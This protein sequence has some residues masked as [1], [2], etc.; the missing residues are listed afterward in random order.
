MLSP[1][2]LKRFPARQN[3][4]LSAMTFI[5]GRGDYNNRGEEVQPGFPEILRS[6]AITSFPQKLSR[7]ALA[8]WIASAQ[9]PLTARVMVNRIWQHHFGR[10]I[11]PGPSE[12]GT[13]GD[14]PSHPELLDWL[15][16]EFI[17]GGWSIKKLHQLILLSETYQ[18]SSVPSSS[19]LARDPDNRLFSRQNR[20]RLEGEVIRDSLLAISGHLNQTVGGPSIFPPIPADMA[21][22]LN[23]WTVSV[24]ASDRSRRSVYIFS[25]RNL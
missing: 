22:G 11:A 10:G 3:S 5:L 6:D 16:R 2:F 1:P 9:N 21:K 23:N 12:F 15:A 14:A 13:R 4:G 17:A 19:A 24:D 25:R 18:Q 8:N 20:V 7:A